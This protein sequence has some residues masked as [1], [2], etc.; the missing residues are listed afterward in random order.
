MPPITGRPHYR[1]YT[2]YNIPT[3]RCLDYIKVKREERVR[4]TKFA[5]SSTGAALASDVQQQEHALSSTSVKTFTP[6]ES[7]D[8]TTVVTLFSAE[9]KEAIRN[10]LA[11]AGSI[12]EVEAIENAVQKGILPDQLLV[13]QQQQAPPQLQKRTNSESNN[14]DVDDNHEMTEPAQK[15]FKGT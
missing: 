8:G 6:G 11:N 15:R 5:K 3:L 9:E 1:L 4:A 12:Q 10:L 14:G 13:L 2:I 7:T